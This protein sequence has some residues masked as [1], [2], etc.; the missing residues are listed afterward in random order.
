MD[1]E[2]SYMDEKRELQ[3]LFRV[4]DEDHSGFLT[5]DEIAKIL[6][7]ANRGVA[8]SEAEVKACMADMDENGDNKI[9]EEEFVDAMLRFMKNTGVISSPKSGAHKRSAD[10]NLDHDV[11]GAN[12]RTI[13][14]CANFFKAHLQSRPDIKEERNAIL[15]REVE[16]DDHDCI[17]VSRIFSQKDKAEA[18]EACMAFFQGPQIAQL[19]E[20]LHS[21]DMAELRG[22]LQDLKKLL[23]LVDAFTSEEERIE[24][25]ILFA[26]IFA[27]ISFPNPT[28]SFTR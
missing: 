7:D 10:S 15:K 2:D 16:I 21:S 11:H 5:Q 4:T 26:Q 8:P 17:D 18:F 27:G 13:F 20:H 1:N 23:I 25:S 22:G 19:Q 6:K 28:P 24:M 14:S 12:K 9:S 3:K